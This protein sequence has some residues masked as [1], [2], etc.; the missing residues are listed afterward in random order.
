MRDVS[1]SGGSANRELHR[2][3]RPEF[4][5]LS[6]SSRASRVTEQPWRKRFREQCM[7]RLSERREQ[8]FLQRR[9]Q[10][11]SPD[12][13]EDETM[14]VVDE[15]LSEQEMCN[16]IKQEWVR[17]KAEMESQSLEYGVLDDGIIEDIED[18]LDLQMKEYA[19][20]EE[21]EQQLLEAEM[22]EMAE[23]EEMIDIDMDGIDDLDI[24]EDGL[25]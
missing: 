23:A 13:D 1:R 14:S 22:A 3:R 8:S 21:Y 5:N 18:G 11:S 16:I 4:R 10:L 17:F 6:N 2:T 15:G 7:D 25:L 12:D 24:N 20:W 19:E 9:Q